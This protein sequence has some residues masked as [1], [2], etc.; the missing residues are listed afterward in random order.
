[1]RKIVR[2]DFYNY[3]IIINFI[4]SLFAGREVLNV[5]KSHVT[6]S[7]PLKSRK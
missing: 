2:V 1:M 6:K 3:N 7:Q 5:T 4:L